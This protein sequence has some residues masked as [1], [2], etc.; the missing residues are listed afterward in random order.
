MAERVAPQQPPGGEDGA[1][2]D[3]IAPDGLH[4]VLRAAGVVLAA[5]PEQRGQRALV[6]ANEGDRAGSHGVP[7]RAGE[8]PSASTSSA[9]TPRTPA[10]PSRSA[11]SRA[12]GRAT[13]T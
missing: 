9:R 6:A 10:A 2:E 3:A 7:S 12:S 5:R 4:R 1:P 13:T 11:R 8:P